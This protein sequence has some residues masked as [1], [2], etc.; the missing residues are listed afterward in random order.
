MAK[1]RFGSKT[2]RDDSLKLPGWAWGQ[3]GDLWV[4]GVKTDKRAYT[5]DMVERAYL[6]IKP[7]LTSKAAKRGSVAGRYVRIS[8]SKS[9]WF[10]GQWQLAIDSN[11]NAMTD[12]ARMS[13]LTV[14]LQTRLAG[15][16][17]LVQISIHPIVASIQDSFFFRFEQSLQS[18]AYP[19]PFL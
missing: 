13:Q 14:Q 19:L 17:F 4:L 7:D 2:P 15:D 10:I 5:H 12:Y 8:P 16:P 11:P 6:A 1:N 18:E 3:K 9:S